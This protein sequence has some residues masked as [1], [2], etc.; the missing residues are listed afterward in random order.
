MPVL[1][2]GGGRGIQGDGDVWGEEDEVGWTIR[3]SDH[4]ATLVVLRPS[5]AADGT[6]VDV[7]CAE[8]PTIPIGAEPDECEGAKAPIP[9]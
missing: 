7:A 5:G 2:P 8:D 4:P 6:A 1:A 9:P 3:D